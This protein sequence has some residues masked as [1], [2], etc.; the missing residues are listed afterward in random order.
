MAD[1]VNDAAIRRLVVEAGFAAVNHGLQ[2]EMRTILASLPDWLDDP[3]VLAACQA[4]LLFGLGDRA[5]AE[6]R[7][8]SADPVLCAP[9]RQL[10]GDAPARAESFGELT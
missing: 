8:D 2:R 5:G 4:T 1:G 6:S 7:L 10:L 9:L 3:A